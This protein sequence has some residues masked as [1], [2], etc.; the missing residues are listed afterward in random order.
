MFLNIIKNGNL[1]KDIK[2]VLNTEVKDII[3]KIIDL[4][5]DFLDDIEKPILK[6]VKDNKIDSNDLPQLILL[7]QNL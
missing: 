7:I 3:I 2:I 1:N 4:S 6:I 5:P